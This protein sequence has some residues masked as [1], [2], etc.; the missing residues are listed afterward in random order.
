MTLERIK[1]AMKGVLPIEELSVD[2]KAIYDDMESM[3][4]W[5]RSIAGNPELAKKLMAEA[6]NVGYDDADNLVETDGK[7]GVSILKSASGDS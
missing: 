5:E 7:G 4:R 6:G 3:Q 2:E 1:A